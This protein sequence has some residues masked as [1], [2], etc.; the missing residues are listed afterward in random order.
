MNIDIY[1]PSKLNEITLSQYQEYIKLDIKD[2]KKLA[3]RILEI[4]CNVS[5]AESLNV[6]VKQVYSIVEHIQNLLD[7]KPPLIQKFRLRGVEYGFIPNLD[8]M[9]F[10]EYIDVD[11]HLGNWDTMHIAMSVLYRPIKDRHKDRYNLVD[12]GVA[13]A[14]V[15]RDM[16]LDVVI[17]SILFFYHLGIELSQIMMNSLEEEQEILTMQETNLLPNGVGIN[18]YTHYLKETLDDL[19]IYL[20]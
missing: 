3:L 13:D 4:F 12:Y 15:L 20:S 10:G 18:L 2:E 11:T 7:Q 8:D 6:N 17:G 9:S 1:I 5:I 19:K 16:P 14:E